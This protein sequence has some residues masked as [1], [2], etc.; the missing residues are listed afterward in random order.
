MTN[1]NRTYQ[2]TDDSEFGV[3]MLAWASA[4]YR[5]NAVH[6]LD[7]ELPSVLDEARSVV[8]S[9]LSCPAYASDARLATFGREL[10]E[11]FLRKFAD[12]YPRCPICGEPI[13][14]CPGHG[15]R[16]L[17]EPA[18]IEHRPKVKS[19]C[20]CLTQHPDD[21]TPC[22]DCDAPAPDGSDPY[23]DR[24][25]PKSDR[26]DDFDIESKLAIAH[27][28]LARFAETVRLAGNDASEIEALMEDL[29]KIET[30]AMVLLHG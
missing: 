7:Q 30:K 10:E 18:A 9:L 21:P 11:A 13:D 4:R 22:P 20:T 29:S 27:Q 15:E 17:E 14:Y 25:L 2:P 23:P 28:A 19:K 26:G 6:I 5:E 1:L 8:A 12:E 16:N 24:D 3:L